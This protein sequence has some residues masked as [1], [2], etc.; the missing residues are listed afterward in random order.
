MFK[1]IG[2]ARHNV[3]ARI[4]LIYSF[5]Q[6]LWFIEA[7][8]YFYWARFLTYSQIG[9]FFSLLVILGLVAEIPT[10][11]IA[12]RY[13]RKQSVVGGTI[14]LFLGA[15]LMTSATSAVL[16]VLGVS[17]MSIGRAFISGALEAIVYDD[18]KSTGKHSHWDSLQSTAI[19]ISL[20]AYILAVPIG[21]FLYNIHF[22]LPNM[23]E[24]ISMFLSI[25]MALK[26]SDSSKQHQLLERKVKI[27]ELLVGFRELFSTRLAPY[28]LPAFMVISIF[29]L[30]DWGLSK[31]AMAVSFGLNSQGQSIVYTLLAI[32]NII[33]I[34]LMPRLRRM[35]GD[36]WGLRMLNL[37]SGM[38]FVASTYLLG[39]WGIGILWLLESAGNL[40]DPW[41]SSVVNEN[42]E[43]K[44][45]A[46]TLSTLAFMTRIP[47]FFVNILAGLALDSYGIGRFHWWLGIAIIL[48]VILSTIS[49]KRPYLTSNT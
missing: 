15:V 37:I 3:N 14:L 31:P 24:A 18:L 36:Y 6:S 20:V 27:R 30:Y 41:T 25:L 4:Y 12:D 22:R 8:W 34:G 11:Y 47:H 49:R 48:L 19:Q 21:G 44:Y 38:A 35:I 1:A 17:V 28:I 45:R 10:G 46:T 40:G 2:I 33:T 23:L 13:G 39:L 32:L 29:E 7:V 5:L 16:L 26:L 42:T 43:S 9:I